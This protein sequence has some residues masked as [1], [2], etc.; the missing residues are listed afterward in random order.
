MSASPPSPCAEAPPPGSPP[1]L[2]AA[3]PA[4]TVRVTAPDLARRAALERTRGRLVIAA[5]G[6][7]VLFAAV[8]VKLAGAT[9]VFPMAS[10]RLEH[11]ARL[12]DPTPVP[13]LTVTAAV[14]VV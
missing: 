10:R 8:V 14:E 7:L 3:V 1:R 13:R 12:P 4:E 2:G 5:G 11:M 9:V 6:F